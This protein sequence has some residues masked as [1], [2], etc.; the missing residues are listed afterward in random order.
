ML[1]LDSN[2]GLGEMGEMAREVGRSSEDICEE[3]IL[4]GQ[5]VG[6]TVPR[7]DDPGLSRYGC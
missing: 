1:D 4:T 3:Y 2:L 5:G 7:V 6:W